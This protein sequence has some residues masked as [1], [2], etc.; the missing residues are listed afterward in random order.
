M[1]GGYFA[2]RDKGMQ[3]AN[4][5]DAEL[6]RCRF[7][8][9]CI[10]EECEKLPSSIALLLLHDGKRMQIEPCIRVYA[11]ISWLMMPTDVQRM[12]G[13]DRAKNLIDDIIVENAANIHICKKEGLIPVRIYG[14]SAAERICQKVAGN[15]QKCRILEIIDGKEKC[16]CF[17]L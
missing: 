12:T 1:W 3:I 13:L 14:K 10:G 4:F 8:F 17:F 16:F 9:V 5:L 7:R 2:L 15:T 6:V 11:G